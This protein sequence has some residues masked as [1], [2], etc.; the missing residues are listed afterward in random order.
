MSEE[1]LFLNV[2]VVSERICLLIFLCSHEDNQ[3]VLPVAGVRNVPL[4]HSKER[5]SFLV[6]FPAV[7]CSGF[8]WLPFAWYA[9]CK[10]P[11]QFARTNH[12]VTFFPLFHLLTFI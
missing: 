10:L 7:P 8:Y 12:I 5:F 3:H 4:F 9:L 11:T 6:S 1:M 2:H